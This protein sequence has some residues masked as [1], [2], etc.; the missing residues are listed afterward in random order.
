[1]STSENLFNLLLPTLRRQ[2]EQL[3]FERP[4]E[5]QALAIPCILN[6]DNALLVAPTGT[7]KTEA[8]IFR[9]QPPPE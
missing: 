4:T 5:I 1:M 2:I 8:V 9:L 6:E 7:G 3:D